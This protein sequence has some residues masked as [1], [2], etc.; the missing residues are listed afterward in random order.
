VAKS[1]RDGVAGFVLEDQYERV[2]TLDGLRG[3]A[4][5]AA[6]AYDLSEVAGLRHDQ[7]GYFS[8]SYLAADFFFCLSGFVLARRHGEELARKR[9]SLRTFYL[10]RLIRLMPLP[11]LVC[12]LAFLMRIVFV[13]SGDPLD[14]DTAVGL[15]INLPFG[16]L[17][18][19]QTDHSFA[20]A[21]HTALNPGAWFVCS[22]ALASGLW[23]TLLVRVPIGMILCVAAISLLVVAPHLFAANTLASMGTGVSSMWLSFARALLSF[24]LGAA[25]WRCSLGKVD[26]VFYVEILGTILWAVLWLPIESNWILDSVCVL[27]LFPTI[28]LF[29][30][31]ARALVSATSVLRFLGTISYPL[32]VLHSFLLLLLVKV[33]E[34][35]PALLSAK[36]MPFV[37]GAW[38]ACAWLASHH[39]DRPARAWIAHKL[40]TGRG[41]S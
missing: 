20:P 23:A 31:E 10:A 41:P 30:A 3:V 19:P 33:S 25:L 28:I 34:L 18:L 5:I 37:L 29:A 38:V 17:T 7:T 21:L 22:A 15:L 32:F 9:M 2:A 13:N 35:Q 27:L 8:H 24:L 16:L 1:E 26:A 12:A 6:A 40:T 14:G 39:V 4:A 36:S 11:A